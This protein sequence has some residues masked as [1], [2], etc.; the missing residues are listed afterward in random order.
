MEQDRFLGQKLQ[1]LN[2]HLSCS[3]FKHV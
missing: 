2:S 3:K 1:L